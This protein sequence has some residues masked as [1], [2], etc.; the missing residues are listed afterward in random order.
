LTLDGQ[1]GRFVVVCAGDDG[2]GGMASVK[3]KAGIAL[4]SNALSEQKVDETKTPSQA[5]RSRKAKT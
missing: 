2:D 1:V 3:R 4:P 5:S